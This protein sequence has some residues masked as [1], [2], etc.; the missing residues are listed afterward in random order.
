[1][2]N[3]KEGLPLPY[4]TRDFSECSAATAENRSKRSAFT[5]VELLVVIAIIGILIGMLLPAIQQVRAAARRTACQ[6][7]LKQI[8]LAIHNYES[9]KMKFPPGQFWTASVADNDPNRLDYGWMA[10]ILPQIE[11]NNIY[12]QINFDLPYRA[13]TNLAAIA[14]VIPA[15]LCPSTSKTDGIR[16]GNVIVELYN[17][18]GLNLGCTD[19]MG[20]SGP[21]TKQVNPTTGNQYQ[22]QQGILIGI[23]ELRNADRITHPPAVTFG[24]ISDGSSN[25]MMVTECTGRGTEKEDDDPNGAWVSGKNITHLDKGVNTESA[26]ESWNDEYIY[27]EHSGGSNAV[28]A[29]GSVHFL[30]D[31]MTEENVMALSSRNGGEVNVQF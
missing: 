12:Q 9:G 24:K 11:A 4:P 8:G 13:P 31:D 20:I 19:Y 7:N 15:F 3:S 18:V 1:M 17:E 29:D 14:N 22:K 28:F 16:E 5:L 6:N 21:S 25:T 10:L 26:K 23:K 30:T 27:S 2:K